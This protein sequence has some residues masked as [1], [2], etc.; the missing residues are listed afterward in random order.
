ML[1]KQCATFINNFKI[2]F[3]WIC[4]SVK[5]ECLSFN[6]NCVSCTH[7]VGVPDPWSAVS[8]FRLPEQRT[9]NLLEAVDKHIEAADNM[10]EPEEA[11]HG[12]ALSP[13]V[14]PGAN[15]P[16][17]AIECC[18]NSG[19]WCYDPRAEPCCQRKNTLFENNWKFKCSDNVWNPDLF[20]FR[21]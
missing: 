16:L 7:G 3:C 12:V 19:L 13:P 5:V 2:V 8:Q 1:I 6:V 9:W 20:K 10:R 18:I 14:P 15:C 4:L 21:F 11:R 17:N